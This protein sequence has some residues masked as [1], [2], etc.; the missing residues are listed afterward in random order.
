MSSGGC[1]PAVRRWEE[2][3]VVLP[4]IRSFKRT[5]CVCVGFCVC[6]CACVCLLAETRGDVTC[7]V[8]RFTQ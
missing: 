7:F 8:F 3:Q 5:V 4:E 6:L 1:L 2:L